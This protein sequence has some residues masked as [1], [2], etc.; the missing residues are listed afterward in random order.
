M[1][2]ML[3]ISKEEI[4]PTTDIDKHLFIERSMRGGYIF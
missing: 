1:D 2:L 3:K 4:D